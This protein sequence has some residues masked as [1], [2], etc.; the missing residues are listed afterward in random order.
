V[1]TIAT[2]LKTRTLFLGTDPHGRPVEFPTHI[3]GKSQAWRK[4]AF[5]GIS[6]SGKTYAAAKMVEQWEK[7]GVPVCVLDSVGVW[8]GLRAGADGSGKGGLTIP[9]YGGSHGDTSLP[10][11][12]QAA[13]LFALKSQSL[14][15]D[16][17]DLNIEEMQLWVAEFAEEL[18]RE[19][20]RPPTVPCHLVIEEAPDLIPQT[21]SASKYTKRCKM[22]L[23]RY[24]RVGRNFGY[25]ASVIAQRTAD[26]DKKSLNMCGTVLLMRIAA[27]IDRK[28]IGGWIAN[29]SSEI[30]LKQALAE[31]CELPSGEGLLWSP[32][33]AKTLTRVKVGKRETFHAGPDEQEAEMVP[34]TLPADLPSAA[35]GDGLEAI[36]KIITFTIKAALVLLGMWLAWKILSLGL[37]VIGLVLLLWIVF[38]K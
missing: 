13:Q 6:G 38:G 36:G 16:L 26:V 27:E 21:G 10:N 23:A 8:W 37:A 1:A 19:G 17:L 31:L 32:T 4:I 35:T 11:P 20:T 7:T 22:A 18:M 5:L 12:I 24:I 9:V 2:E 30:D 3:D 15:L 14:I 28:A 33:W 25:G 34:I 29:N